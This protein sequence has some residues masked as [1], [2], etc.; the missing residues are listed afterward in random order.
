MAAVLTLVAMCGG[1]AS[2]DPV[3][4]TETTT[5]T[6]GDYTLDFSVT[7]N[8]GGA[9]QI[10]FF[11]VLLDSGTNIVGSPTGFDTHF[12]AWSNAPYGGSSL[13]YNNTWIDEN[14]VGI[15]SGATW[16][17]FSVQSTDTVLPSSINW[18]AYAFGGTYTGG[19]NFN[20]SWNPGFE[21]VV[22]LQAVP[23]PSTFLVGLVGSLGGLGYWL[24]KSRTAR[25]RTQSS[26]GAGHGLAALV[27]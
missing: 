21:G 24:R 19:G 25:P 23:E 12:D 20:S 27:A 1:R 7:N 18:F 10:Y 13:V 8:L 9:N 2:A 5:G 3:L 6:P 16:N 4:V 14:T 22:N 26:S 17:G 15:P 11:G